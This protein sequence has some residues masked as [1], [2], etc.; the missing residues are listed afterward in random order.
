MTANLLN[1]KTFY[2]PSKEARILS[3]LDS[4]ADGENLSQQEIGKKTSLSS[5]MINQYLK[6]LQTKNLIHYERIN[7]KSYR[8]ILT[9]QGEK[10]RRQ[11]FSVYSSET[12]QMYSALKEIV[13]KKLSSLRERDI[14]K[15]VLFGAS[16]TCEIVLS[17]IKTAQTFDIV[18]LA[19][20]TPQKHGKLLNGHVISP[21][22]ILD[23]VTCQ[24][25]IVTSFGYTDEITQQLQP[26]VE[27]NSV[28]IVTL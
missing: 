20:N 16:E 27:K 17:A 10:K 5:A 18:A 9:P 3:I 24:A 14:T 7:G 23:S 25:I 8:Y 21:P 22:E 13:L 11:M 26:F 1:N 28:E 6:E 15:V 2:R 19:D 4:L 12:V